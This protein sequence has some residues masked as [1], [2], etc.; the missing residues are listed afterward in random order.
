MNSYI[1]ALP[2]ATPQMA[3]MDM[4]MD[5]FI[6]KKIYIIFNRH[7]IG[8]NTSSETI[9]WIPIRI[10]KSSIWEDHRSFAFLSLPK[11]HWI[12]IPRKSVYKE[13]SFCLISIQVF[14]YNSNNDFFSISRFAN[15]LCQFFIHTNEPFYHHR[16][17]LLKEKSNMGRKIIKNLIQTNI[18]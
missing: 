9:I 18:K 5:R 10:E 17:N 12:H 4:I 13:M 2:M 8:A 7:H 1:Q 11:S 3:R 6:S 14:Y 16:M 15:I